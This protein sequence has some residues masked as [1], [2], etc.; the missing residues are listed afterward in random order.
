M[1]PGTKLIDVHPLISRPQRVKLA[2]FRRVALAAGTV[3]DV[4]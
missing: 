2:D 1:L 4:D 3:A